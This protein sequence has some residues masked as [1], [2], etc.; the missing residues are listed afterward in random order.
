MCDSVYWDLLGS[1]ACGLILSAW[2]S[3]GCSVLGRCT[4]AERFR[5]GP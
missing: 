2:N 4:L 3:G 5:L 1:L